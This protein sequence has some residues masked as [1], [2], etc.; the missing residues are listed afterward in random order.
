MADKFQKS[1]FDNTSFDK[2]D[3]KERKTEEAYRKND[4]DLV[5]FEESEFDISIADKKIKETIKSGISD[6]VSES[7][8]IANEEYVFISKLKKEEEVRSYDALLDWLKDIMKD[9]DNFLK[10]CEAYP[11]LFSAE[12]CNFKD[13]DSVRSKTLKLKKVILELWKLQV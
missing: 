5:D 4:E 13:S 11:R 7:E 9:S 12:N 2:R 10:I 8:L 3:K 6:R 1:G